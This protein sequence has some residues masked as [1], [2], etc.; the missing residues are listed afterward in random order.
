ML[1][2]PMFSRDGETVL[3]LLLGTATA[4]VRPMD[5]LGEQDVGGRVA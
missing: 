1:S 2:Y 3:I 5:I 4:A